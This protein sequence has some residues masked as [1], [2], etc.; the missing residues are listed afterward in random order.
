MSKNTYEKLSK[1][2]LDYLVKNRGMDPRRITIIKGSPRASTA[3]EIWIVPPGAPPP[4]P[5]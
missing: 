3:F 1:R 5:N 2:T 4:V